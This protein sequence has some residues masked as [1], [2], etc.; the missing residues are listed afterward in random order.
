MRTGDADARSRACALA[1]SLFYRPVRATSSRRARPPTSRCVGARRSSASAI[2]RWGRG[3]DTSRF[4]P[5]KPDRGRL[6]RRDQGPLRR[7][8]DQR[9]GRRPA[10]R[11]LP[12]RPRERDPRLHLLLAGGGPEEERAA[13]AASATRATFLGWLDGE[14]ARRAPTRAPTSS[15]SASRTDTYGQV[16][17]RGRRQRPAG[18]RRRRGR[19]GGADRDRRHT[20]RLCAPDAGDAGGGAAAA[21]RRRPACARE[22]RRAGRARRRSGAHLGGVACAQLARRLRP[23]STRARRRSRAS[24]WSGRLSNRP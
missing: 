10:G 24:S 18:R 22:A 19:P 15:S 2:G 4:D 21:R 1:L 7:P 12:A 23:G 9:E 5:A 3:V 13:R 11:G 16:I 8:A 6:P 17:A 20:G 14:R